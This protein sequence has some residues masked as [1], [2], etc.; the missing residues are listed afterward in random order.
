MKTKSKKKRPVVIF[1]LGPTCA[2][3]SELAVKLARRIKGEIISCD[4]MQIYK[5]MP[6][7]SQRPSPGTRRGVRHHLIGALEP[8]REWNAARFVKTASAAAKDIIRRGRVPIVAGGTGLYARSLIKGL[9]PSP[10]GD[11]KTRR[12]LYAEASSGGGDRLYARLMKI[13]PS[14]ASVIH[15]NDLRRVVRALEVY[16]LT[17]I[18]LSAH[19]KRARGMQDEYDVRIF[20]LTR[21][22]G[23]LYRRIEARVDRMFK[24]GIVREVRRL[25]RGRMGRTAKAALGYKEINDY[26]IGRCG[27]REAG[28][29]LKKNTRRYAKR[30]LTW[31]RKEK[32]AVWLDAGA[33]GVWKRLYSLL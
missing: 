14:Y 9:F 2:G 7:L 23:E 11:R 25:R 18:P 13:D 24:S 28:E 31:F 12:R 17:G 32:G 20:V 30:Q 1:I 3:K 4:S 15:P 26:L 5:Y 27:L 19:H 22:R 6:V 8:S 21:P 16:E 33:P 10:S 29:T